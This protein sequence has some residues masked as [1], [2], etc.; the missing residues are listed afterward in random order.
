MNGRQVALLAPLCLCVLGCESPAPGLKIDLS[1]S[2]DGT[3]I[4]LAIGQSLLCLAPEYGSVGI[5]SEVESSDPTI[6][7]LEKDSTVYESPERMKA[8]MTGADGASRQRLFRALKAGEAWLEYRKIFRG[9]LEESKRLR[10]K[11]K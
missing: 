6:L 8:G 7:S 4:N 5:D 10:I 9:E 2:A 3:E 1:S 11:V